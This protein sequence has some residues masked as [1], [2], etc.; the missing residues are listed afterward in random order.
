MK[1]SSKSLPGKISSLRSGK[2]KGNTAGGLYFI[3]NDVI[4][5]G[6]ESFALVSPFKI[7]VKHITKH[8]VGAE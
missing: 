3:Q 1:C 6:G 5:V 8:D 2:G 4:R 7:G